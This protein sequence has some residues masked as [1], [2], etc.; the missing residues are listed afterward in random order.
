MMGG[1]ATEQGDCSRF[2]GII[3]H[4]CQK[5]PTIVDFLPGT[6]YNQQIANC[7]KGGVISSWIQDPANA[8]SSFQITVGQAGTS[9]KTVRLPKNFTLQAPG[10]GYTCGQAKIVKPSKFFS[11]PDKRRVTQALSKLFSHSFLLLDGH[12]FVLFRKL[13]FQ[14]HFLYLTGNESHFWLIF[15]WEIFINDSVEEREFKPY[16][17]PIG[18]WERKWWGDYAVGYLM[19]CLT[20]PFL[21]DAMHNC[22]CRLS[23]RH[24]MFILCIQSF[25]RAKQNNP[26]PDQFREPWIGEDISLWE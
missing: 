16:Q 9:N 15:S 7:C 8:A 13:E 1:Q 19:F 18:L 3:P 14:F 5:K 17:L 22:A 20:K 4:S 6:P 21:K 23:P 11:T 12:I 25:C 24:M 26:Q 2:K 10:P